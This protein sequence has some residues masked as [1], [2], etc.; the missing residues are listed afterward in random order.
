MRIFT[1]QDLQKRT[2]EVQEAALVGPIAIT[3]HGR[4]RHVMLSYEEYERLKKTA[5][6]AYPKTRVYRMK[7]IPDELLKDL[8]E[9][10]MDARHEHLNEIMSE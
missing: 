8:A 1:S 2:G 3:H 9:A 6:R 4:K 5:K 7:E 10:E